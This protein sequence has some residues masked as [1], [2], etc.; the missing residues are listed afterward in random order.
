[1]TRTIAAIVIA[2]GA[3]LRMGSPKPLVQWRGR[4]FVRHVIDALRSAGCDPIVVVEGAHAL[5]DDAITPA[6]RVRHEGWAQGP[7]SSMQ[8]G[9]R[10][11]G[12][13]A[14]LLATVDRPHVEA[15]T[16]AALLAAH[17]EDRD[18]VVQPLHEGRRGHP[19]ILPA[20]LRAA[21]L[22]AAPTDNLRALLQSARR[23]EVAVDDPAVLDNIDT[24]ADLARLPT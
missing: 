4:A 3:S 15:S 9:L 11:T 24:P 21:V 1:M 13:G 7:L 17:A 12:E 22:A 18:A 2:A 20:S 19:L 8:A 16:I 10:A 5:P 14:V 6:R 23:H